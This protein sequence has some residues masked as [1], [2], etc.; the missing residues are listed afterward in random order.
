[1]MQGL[2]VGYQQAPLASTIGRLYTEAVGDWE[3]LLALIENPR[4]DNG[5]IRMNISK[6]FDQLS[7]IVNYERRNF[8]M[9]D[10]GRFFAQPNYNVAHQYFLILAQRALE[11]VGRSPGGATIYFDLEEIE[12]PVKEL[13]L[14]TSLPLPAIDLPALR[15]INDKQRAFTI[16]MQQMFTALKAH[17]SWVYFGSNDKESTEARMALADADGVVKAFHDHQIRQDPGLSNP[18]PSGKLMGFADIV[19]KID[20]LKAEPLTNLS[21]LVNACVQLSTYVSTFD[22]LSKYHFLRKRK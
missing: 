20:E 9:S 1:V 15:G 19:K 4:L 16:R 2:A 22:S 12:P 14:L 21:G 5:N 8:W 7:G 17:W 3:A 18:V 11:L 6:F 10:P 13:S